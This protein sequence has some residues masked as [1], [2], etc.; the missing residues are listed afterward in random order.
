MTIERI[1]DGRDFIRHSTYAEA[2]Q[3]P[4]KPIV[5]ARVTFSLICRSASTGRSAAPSGVHT[6]TLV[7]REPLVAL[8]GRRLSVL[9]RLAELLLVH[10]ATAHGREKCRATDGC[11]FH[12][13]LLRYVI[14]TW[15]C[16]AT[17]GRGRPR[18]M[19]SADARRASRATRRGASYT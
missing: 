10:S 19:P 17:Y 1:C 16:S 2:P 12:P 11:V 5:R 3:P 4:K 8:R 14:S 13:H 15:P 18:K 7:H 6:R 9:L